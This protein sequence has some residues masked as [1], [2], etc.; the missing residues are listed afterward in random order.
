MLSGD[1]LA[2][3]A[4]EGWG[5][6][7]RRFLPLAIALIGL[8]LVLT[9]GWQRML[10]L[11]NIV[12]HHHLIDEFVAG[13][14][15]AA[16][17]VFM[18]VYIA[19]ASLSVPTCSILTIAGGMVFGF[20][21]GGAA[22]VV[23]ATAGAIVVFF[24]AKTAFG[25]HLVRRAG[26][27]AEKLAGGFRADAFSYLLFLRLVP[28]VPFWLVNLAAA[29]FN[30]RLATFAAAT[31]IGIVPATFAFAFAGSSLRSVIAAEEQ[32]YQACVAAGSADC[33]LRFDVAAALTPQTIGALVVLAAL[34]LVP[35]LVRHLRARR[36]ATSSAR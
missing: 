2:R 25:E 17:A 20:L 28:V 15:L 7:W 16:I 3:S 9:L 35:I 33:R 29:L 14:L 19:V 21:I 23:S 22:S 24:I 26:P 32:A 36:R 8:A 27:A 4:G 1:D 18:A 30:V 12:R 13:H 31:A 10:S 5:T 11:D 6:A 34:A